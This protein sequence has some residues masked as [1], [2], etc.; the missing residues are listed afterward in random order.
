M[1]ILLALLMTGRTFFVAPDG[2]DAA[3][4]LSTAH[5]WR[6]LDKVSHQHFE[7]GDRVELATGST[8][9][10]ALN[11]TSG[12][13][14]SKPVVVFSSGAPA[15]IVSSDQPAITIRTGGIEVKNLILRGG[16]TTPKKGH[17]GILLAAPGDRRS[18]FVR[19]DH[20]DVSG[21]GAEGISMTG[22]KESPN[23]FDDVRISNTTV[24]QNYDTGVATSDGIAA[25]DKGFAHHNLVI[26]DCDVSDNLGGNGIIL[27]GVD[28]AVVEYCRADRNHSANGALGMWAWCAKNVIFRYCIASGT[29]GK[30]DA[31]GFDLDGGTV[32]CRVDHC[33]TF[34]N[35]GPGYMH[36][37]Y[38]DAPR[39][40]RNSMEN[41]ISIDDGRRSG[42]AASGFGFVV[43]GTGLYDCSIT[44]NL[45]ILTKPDPPH[46]EGGLLFATFIR[47]DSIPLSVQRLEGAV[48]KDN[49]AEIRAG[50]AAFVNVNFPHLNPGDLT[51]KGNEYKGAAP[52]LEGAEA[53]KRSSLAEWTATTGDSQNGKNLWPKASHIEDYRSL[54]P[55]DLPSFFS[56][57]KS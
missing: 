31:G 54:R 39:T 26:T 11:L 44:G 1:T 51:F 56:K 27:S 46:Q 18:V 38:P 48:F 7:A 55:R 6:S 30:S 28:G 47:T 12:G 43:W 57:L 17:E 24:H 16:A 35:D 40:Q 13:T 9:P 50:G 23:G 45:A 25:S 5:A 52:F 34:D 14:S 36:C 53:E 19:I 41:S 3:D 22:E 37:D 33:L 21:F 4:G 42:G 49:L 8:F 29:R 2:N 10:G 20:V 15:T 32:D